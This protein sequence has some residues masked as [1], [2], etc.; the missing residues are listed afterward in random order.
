MYL[1]ALKILEL[2]DSK[3]AC[4]FQHF[5]GKCNYNDQLDDCKQTGNMANVL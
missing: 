5:K 3:P 2:S 1:V 4:Y